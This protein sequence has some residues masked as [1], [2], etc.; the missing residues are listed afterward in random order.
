MVQRFLLG[1]VLVAVAVAPA[2]ADPTWKLDASESAYSYVCGGDDWVAINGSGNTVTVSGECALLEVNGSDN[3]IAI[4][5]VA[6]IRVSG[7]NNDVRYARA[8]KG[9]KK[10]VIKVKGAAN[11]VRRGD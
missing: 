6:T 5:A 9:K 10:P 1:M 2:V 11:S 4:E 3:R 7:N 8:V